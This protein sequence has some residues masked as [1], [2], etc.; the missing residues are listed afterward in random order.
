VRCAGQDIEDV[1]FREPLVDPL[2]QLDVRRSA[3][4]SSAKLEVGDAV[5]ADNEQ[6]QAPR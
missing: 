5:V 4:Q 1:A 2:F 3:L 6:R